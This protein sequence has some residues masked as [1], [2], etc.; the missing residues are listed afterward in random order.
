MQ[1]IDKALLSKLTAEAR[2][3]KR[4]RKN[5]NFHQDYNEILQRWLN[6]IEPESYIQPHKHENPD[7]TEVVIALTGRFLVIEFD[8]PGNI[9]ETM[10]LDAVNGPFGTEISPRVYHTVIS[11]EKGGVVYEFKEGPFDPANP[12]FFAPWA[13][14]ED[15]EEAAI[16]MRELLNKTRII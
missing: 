7:K 13:P 16:Y 15:T 2:A 8:D 9:I 10:V 4:L 5:Y 14:A 3:S 12:K 6:A 1:R 11:L